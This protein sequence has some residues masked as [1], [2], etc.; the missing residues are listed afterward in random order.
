[1]STDKSFIPAPFK[2]FGKA[3]KDLFKKKFDY[4]H[5]FKFVNKTA[6]GLSFEVNGVGSAFGG[7]LKSKY[8]KKG[9][10][11]I[12][13]D[14]FTNVKKSSKVT[15][16]VFGLAKGVTVTLVG[17]SLDDD[18]VVKFSKSTIAATVE[19]SQDF[20]SAEASVKSDSIVH[21][22]DAQA[23]IGFDGFS[24]GGAVAFN[25]TKGLDAVSKNVGVE[26]SNSNV[27]LSLY[28]EN[29]SDSVSSGYFQKL[30]DKTSVGAVI[31]TDLTEVQARSLTF[32]VEHKIDTLTSAKLSAELPKGF[33]SVA[34]EH[35][36]SSPRVLLNV[37]AQFNIAAVSSPVEKFG[38]GLSFGDF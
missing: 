18:R 7:N 16:K 5:N 2:N 22:V 28:T 11:E 13:A 19:Y 9:S 29:N 23:S 15:G 12:D 34:V 27:T 36:L 24:V 20:L 31:K 1:M 30:D 14:I 38:L 8:A 10:V 37:A 26:Y 33:V 17:S 25:A 6:N 4:D 32:G 35:K 3:S 21:K